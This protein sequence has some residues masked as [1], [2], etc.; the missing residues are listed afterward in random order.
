[1][2]RPETTKQTIKRMGGA[3][4]VARMCCVHR[5]TVCRWMSGKSPMPDIARRLLEE[6]ERGGGVAW[7]H[8][9][10]LKEQTK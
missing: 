9:A 10:K 6:I 2:I 7:S 8:I 4:K 5:T 3:S 1:M